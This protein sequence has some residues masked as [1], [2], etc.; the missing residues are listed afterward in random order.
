MTDVNEVPLSEEPVVVETTPVDQDE[1][2]SKTDS[3]LLLKS[4]QD[5][6]NLRRKEQEDRKRLEDELQALKSAS[7]TN[8]VVSDEGKA[9]QTQIVNLE[10]KLRSLED[11]KTLS[12]LQS[13]FPALKDKLSEFNEFKKDYPNGKEEQVAKI[14]LAENG[15]LETPTVRKGLENKSGGGRTPQKEGLTLEEISELRVK[16]FPQYRKMLKDGQFNK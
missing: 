7:V 5:E 3:T 4:L 16:N 9:L 14:F 10:G 2:G 6:R 1:P 8:D 12:E 15:L 11:E 13:K